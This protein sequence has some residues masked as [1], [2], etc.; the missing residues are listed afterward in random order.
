[1]PSQLYGPTIPGLAIP[2][3]DHI[4]LSPPNQPTT[5]TYRQGGASGAVVA[6]LTLTYSGTDVATVARS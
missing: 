4:T 6:T 1:M 2:E 3:H 5:I